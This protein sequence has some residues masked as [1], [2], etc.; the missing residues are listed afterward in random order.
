M[1]KMLKLKRVNKYVQNILF[2]INNYKLMS[3]RVSEKCESVGIV[4]LKVCVKTLHSKL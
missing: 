3:G 1:R 4:C 2:I